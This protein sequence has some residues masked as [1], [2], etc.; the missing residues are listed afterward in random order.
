VDKQTMSDSLPVVVDTLKDLIDTYG[1][2]TLAIGLN[3]VGWSGRDLDELL[4]HES[5]EEVS[6]LNLFSDY[7][8]MRKRAKD[9]I[10]MKSNP[11]AGNSGQ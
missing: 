4:I 8:E 2:V 7:T 3:K 5:M 1:I 11:S 6:Q 9:M 10:R